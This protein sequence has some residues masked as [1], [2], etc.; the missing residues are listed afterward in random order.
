MS[1]RD[2]GRAAC[3]GWASRRS[4]QVATRAMVRSLWGRWSIESSGS[5]GRPSRKII[6]RFSQVK[7]I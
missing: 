1:V 4:R 6:C 5:P 3:S 2:P 7:G